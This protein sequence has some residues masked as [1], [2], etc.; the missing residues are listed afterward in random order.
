MRELP[1]VPAFT[2]SVEL[3][4]VA[5]ASLDDHLLSLSFTSLRNDVPQHPAVLSRA[6]DQSAPVPT[7]GDD[8]PSTRI[9]QPVS[10]HRRLAAVKPPRH[11]PR[12]Q[13]DSLILLE[14]STQTLP[15]DLEG[16]LE[17]VPPGGPSSCPAG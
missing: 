7:F 14:G 12:P 10:A 15:Y 9:A 11:G 16:R 1:P 6:P 2:S 3:Y 5:G 8:R 13:F 4:K 17:G